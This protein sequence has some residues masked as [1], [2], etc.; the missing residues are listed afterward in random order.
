MPKSNQN[1]EQ[2]LQRVIE[3]MAK[4]RDPVNG[5]PWDLQQTWHS[6]IAHT[7]EEAYEVVDAIENNQD[8]LVDELGD[9]LFQVVFYSR[10]AEEQNLFNLQRVIQ[11][12]C[13]KLEQRHPHVF[14]TEG[15]QSS[16]SDEQ[17]EKA[18]HKTKSSERKSKQQ[19]SAVDDIP[20]AMPALSRAQKIQ[21]RAANEG[22][23]WDD[24][25]DVVEKIE[26]EILEL[27]QA[28]VNNDSSEITE[29]MGDLLFT[30]VNLS[31]HLKLD[32]E[33]CLRQ[34]S[35]KFEQR[36]R[37]VEQIYNKQNKKINEISEDELN[38][39]WTRVKL[40]QSIGKTDDT[41]NH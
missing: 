21:H 27:K 13:D 40:N 5:C 17:L 39:T 29:E 11:K 4:L 16:I 10:I 6:L 28:L 32:A 12:L 35:G 15:T 31:R 20:L 19:Y 25:S 8:S 41:T 34:S 26:E 30:I 23:D 1:P 38:E 14:T 36:F 3:V 37:A 2:S 18:W 9:L 22:F 7:L 33:T 24:Y